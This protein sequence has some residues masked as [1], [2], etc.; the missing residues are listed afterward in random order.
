VF[1][2]GGGRG[3]AIFNSCYSVYDICIDNNT[4]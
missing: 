2:R 3:G 4:W 1:L